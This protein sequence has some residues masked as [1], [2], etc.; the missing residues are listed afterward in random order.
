[1]KF[2]LLS[3][4]VNFSGYSVVQIKVS[5]CMPSIT[6]CRQYR[7]GYGSLA[8][9]V[10][11][12]CKHDSSCSRIIQFRNKKIIEARILYVVTGTGTANVPHDCCFLVSHGN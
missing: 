9:S 5:I 4:T 1:M 2:K 8:G 6:P 12:V 11:Y 3:C 10:E 7:A